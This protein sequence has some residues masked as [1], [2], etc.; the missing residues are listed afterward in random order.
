[1]FFI[2]TKNAI[3][4]FLLYK[5]KR[6]VISLG[7]TKPPVFYNTNFTRYILGQLFAFP[8]AWIYGSALMWVTLQITNSPLLLGIMG[9]CSSLPYLVL[10]PITGSMAERYD[11]RKLT[12]L[13]NVINLVQSSLLA[14]L[15]F[16]GLVNYPILVIFALI[17]GVAGAIQEPARLA[18]LLDM[19]GPEHLIQASAL[20]SVTFNIARILGPIIAGILL[21]IHSGYCFAL[22]AL[23][24]IP[25]IAMFAIIDVKSTKIEPRGSMLV[26]FV[27]G[28]RYI[29]GQ[30]IPFLILF[31][32]VLASTFGYGITILSSA[33]ASEVL[34]LGSIGYGLLQSSVGVGALT[35]A[36]VISMTKSRQGIMAKFRTSS[37][38]QAVMGL[39]LAAVLLLYPIIWLAIPLYAIFGYMMVNQNV[40]A[41]SILPMVTQEGYIGRV[42]GFYSFAVSGIMPFG[43]LVA[44]GLTQLLTI[45]IGLLV[46]YAI[47]VIP[48]FAIC[49]SPK[50]LNRD[51]FQNKIQP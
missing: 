25:S 32:I 49:V 14:L 42:M 44:G 21:T 6:H 43:N 45:P 51:P 34:K 33:I 29:S 48:T 19:V 28:A 31:T 47:L 41:I 2:I 27:E 38:M 10:A 11:R 9:M 35:G 5:E 16:A 8:S 1:M 15:A 37:I 39:A 46:S 22:A 50:A 18:F 36:L 17:N 12:L 40:L 20:G 26:Q 13:T 3:T 4:I 24:T 30:K 7:M 23:F